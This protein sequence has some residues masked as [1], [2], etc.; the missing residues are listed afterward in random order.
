MVQVNRILTVIVG[1]M[2][3]ASDAIRENAEQGTSSERPHFARLREATT[4]AISKPG[5]HLAFGSPH[6]GKAGEKG[7]NSIQKQKNSWQAELFRTRGKN[8]KGMAKNDRVKNDRVKNEKSKAEKGKDGF[9][10][11]KKGSSKKGSKSSKGKKGMDVSISPSSILSNAPNE[12]SESPTDLPTSRS[13]IPSVPPSVKL[14]LDESLI[15][16][17]IASSG[18]SFLPTDRANPSVQPLQSVNSNLPSRA[19]NRVD[20]L[21]RAPNSIDTPSNMPAN[22]NRPTLPSR[23]KRPSNTPSTLESTKSHR[24]SSPPSR[25]SQSPNDDSTPTQ[26]PFVTPSET[27]NT[28]PID[29]PESSSSQ[30][31]SSTS[32]KNGTIHLT[33]FGIQYSITNK[34][35]PGSTDYS[36]VALLTDRYLKKY[37][38]SIYEQTIFTKLND[39]L[40]VFISANFIFEEPIQLDF[41]ATAIFTAEST[42]LPSMDELDTLLNEAF[43]GTNLDAYIVALSSL[44]ASNYFSGT[45]TVMVTNS[46]SVLLN[47]DPN[48]TATTTT[49]TTTTTLETNTKTSAKRETL[50]VSAVFWTVGSSLGLAAVAYYLSRKQRHRNSPVKPMTLMDPLGFIGESSVGTMDDVSTSGD[51]SHEIPMKCRLISEQGSLSNETYMS[52]DVTVHPSPSSSHHFS[53]SQ[54]EG[55]D[56]VMMVGK[57]T[58][59]CQTGAFEDVH[60]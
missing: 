21:P 20:V 7:E 54:P 19:P 11:Q 15:P 23:S 16:S 45:L 60:L 34:E 2:L 59:I 5:V 28:T 13:I 32:S 3:A 40:T 57:K 39:F 49:A 1:V 53:V 36:D 4:R 41:E 10:N 46:S 44:P 50:V 26:P 51:S 12:T 6:Q 17:F 27:P 52:W 14:T 43:V 25:P 31:P 35:I 56:L 42:I 24:P 37:F 55:K 29:M 8:D 18:P 30:N 47:N 38:T 9:K 33:P 48:K 22:P 58:R